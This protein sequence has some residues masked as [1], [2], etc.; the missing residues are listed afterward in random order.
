MSETIHD[1]IA[2]VIATTDHGELDEGFSLRT[3]KRVA[4]EIIDSL[5]LTAYTCC[6]ECTSVT[7]DGYYDTAFD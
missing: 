4:Q 3:A 7:I 5:G 6:D 1:R 2:E